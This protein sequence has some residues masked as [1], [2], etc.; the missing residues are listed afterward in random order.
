MRLFFCYLLVWALLSGCAAFGTKS[1][2]NDTNPLPTIT[3]VALVTTK[4]SVP[5]VV[6]TGVVDTLF[7]KSLFRHLTAATGWQVEW[8]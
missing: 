2:F 8:S 5:S 1:K 4:A 7:I 6:A 3:R